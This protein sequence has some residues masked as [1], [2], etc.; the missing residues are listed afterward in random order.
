MTLEKYREPIEADFHNYYDVEDLDDALTHKGL[1]WVLGRI[2]YLPPDAALWRV[3]EQ[4]KPIA[5][6]DGETVTIRPDSPEE[7]VDL[8]NAALN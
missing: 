2:K 6:S 7:A 3:Q 4:P 5:S 8:I 1:R